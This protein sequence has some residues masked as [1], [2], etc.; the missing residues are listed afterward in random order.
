[1]AMRP[2]GELPSG[3]HLAPRASQSIL[4][5]VT[6]YKGS[7]DVEHT[8]RLNLAPTDARGADASG[9][10]LCKASPCK[11]LARCKR[12]S[13]TPRCFESNLSGLVCVRHGIAKVGRRPTVDDWKKFISAADDTKIASAR[14]TPSSLLPKL[15]EAMMPARPL[16]NVDHGAPQAERLAE[17]DDSMRIEPSPRAT[18]QD[19]PQGHDPYDEGTVD[20][21][22]P[23]DN[24]AR[25]LC[26][27]ARPLCSTK[28]LESPA[29]YRFTRAFNPN[30][31]PFVPGQHALRSDSGC[32]TLAAVRIIAVARRAQRPRAA[33]RAGAAESACAS[34]RRRRHE[35]RAARCRCPRRAPWALSSTASRWASA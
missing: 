12:S 20:N 27:T 23:L 18:E 17:R 13:C 24:T 4:A 16:S 1:M 9:L 11:T 8:M 6:T 25:P 14:C 33:E 21:V 19:G 2:R 35:R 26:N 28:R 10:V 34:R 29:G 30:A 22:R 7:D 31:A 3:H 15:C 5:S 32:D